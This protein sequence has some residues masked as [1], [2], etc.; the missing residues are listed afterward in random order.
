MFISS[1]QLRLK[2]KRLLETLGFSFMDSKIL[3]GVSLDLA[4][5]GLPIQGLSSPLPLSLTFC[6][7]LERVDSH[8][9]S[10]SG[11]RPLGIWQNLCPLFKESNNTNGIDK[12]PRLMPI[13]VSN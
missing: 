6:K 7:I 4:I 1:V 10:L 9:R 11:Y 12:N 5:F 3:H 2:L 13:F 8:I